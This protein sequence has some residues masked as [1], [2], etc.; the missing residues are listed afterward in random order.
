MVK[1]QENR[2]GCLLNQSPSCYFQ[3]WA[4]AVKLGSSRTN[5]S[6]HAGPVMPEL[7]AGPF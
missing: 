1:S 6:V 4:Y 2:A 3:S 7:A 5:R